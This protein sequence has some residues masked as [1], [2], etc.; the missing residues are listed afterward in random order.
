[1][2]ETIKELQ[3][4]YTADT[5][6]VGQATDT[7]KTSMA[8]LVTGIGAGIVVLNQ[9]QQLFGTV[10]R[11]LGELS[12][13]TM[14]AV[15]AFADFS[16]GMAEV[17]T[18][19]DATDGQ[20][21]TLTAGVMELSGQFG[22][23]QTE[24][25]RALYNAISAGAAD[26]GNAVDFLSDAN[27]AAIAGVTD[28]DSAVR[29]LAGTINA[30]GLSTDDATEVSDILF[31]TV[32]AGVLTFSDLSRGLGRVTSVAATAGIPL[33]Q[34]TAALA[35]LTKSGIQFDEAVTSLRQIII[36]FITPTKDAL[37]VAEGLGIE[38]SAAA[39]KS[40]G[41]GGALADVAA[42][43][44]D[45]TE[46]L[47]KMFGNVR[48]FTGAAAL[49]GK[50]A[51]SFAEIIKENE[52]AAG[53]TQEAYRKMSEE[54]AFTFRQIRAEWENFKITIGQELEPLIRL[55]GGTILE[56][57][58]EL[59]R[60]IKE[61]QEEID[62]LLE[63]AKAVARFMKKA[64][65]TRPR[66]VVRAIPVVG[67]T[68]E[69]AV[70]G[71]GDKIK[72]MLRKSIPACGM[73]ERLIWGREGKID[74]GKVQKE[75]SSIFGTFSKMVKTTPLFSDAV[76]DDFKKIPPLINRAT[77]FIEDMNQKVIAGFKKVT[78]AFGE[79]WQKRIQIAGKQLKTLVNQEKSA[80]DAVKA[81]R[82]T[83]KGFIEGLNDDIV[84]IE[85]GGLD[86]VT[87]FQAQVALARSE[88]ERAAVEN[89]KGNVE[90]SI[91]IAE[92]ARNMFIALANTEIETESGVAVAREDANKIAIDG[93]E[94]V[95]DIAVAGFDEQQEVAEDALSRIRQNIVEVKDELKDLRKVA[96]ESVASIDLTISTAAAKQQI[97]DFTQFVRNQFAGLG[98]GGFAVQE[99]VGARD[100]PGGSAG[101]GSVV[102][103]FNINGDAK[104]IAEEIQR[105]QRRGA[106]E[107]IGG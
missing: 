68:A 19:I 13:A 84:S 107:P 66:D 22:A 70:W 103:N 99:A 52:N 5:S 38:L 88:L 92:R 20:M 79:E 39:L 34:L 37:E 25:T 97:K 61:N 65:L 23:R 58:K 45:N 40:K 96:L 48:A 46:A 106:L 72:E 31:S 35:A 73:A 27:R 3:I 69:K 60:F 101:K 75:L 47:A 59:S 67:P 11:S 4:K 24:Q 12:R 63:G 94:A 32:R 2:A 93:L 50:Q 71:F 29:V 36:S 28:V 83:E 41:L 80:I 85:L 98:V 54:V 9:L 77:Q 16:E 21:E 104:T 78:A 90:E 26:A 86:E 55:I 105:L 64:A 18:L 100:M 102:N 87:R 10:T 15:N 33:T 43:A 57:V 30:Y 53:A 95:R 8:G 91:R 56:S 6:E 62:A 7:A 81:L 51:A 42:K 17:S 1:M 14:E 44:G 76:V 82:E 89:Q 49:A 74:E